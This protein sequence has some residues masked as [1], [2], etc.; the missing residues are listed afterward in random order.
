MWCNV[1]R[2]KEVSVSNEHF[3]L[4]SS[5]T[6]WMKYVCVSWLWVWAAY[7][8]WTGKIENWSQEFYELEFFRVCSSIPF[9]LGILF[10]FSLTYSFSSFWC[11]RPV[12]SSM[13]FWKTKTPYLSLLN[14]LSHKYL[15]EWYLRELEN[16]TFPLIFWSQN[17]PT[18]LQFYQ[19][20]PSSF[21]L[22]RA[23]KCKKLIK[24]LSLWDNVIGVQRMQQPRKLLSCSSDKGL[25]FILRLIPRKSN[26]FLCTLWL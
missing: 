5:L 8:L 10:S 7:L 14:L 18:P 22:A 11:A 12:K 6:S 23:L 20:I 13:H 25:A 2:S 19:E 17:D 15:K 26:L 21:S 3:S 4:S 16:D 24:H 9:F 1:Q